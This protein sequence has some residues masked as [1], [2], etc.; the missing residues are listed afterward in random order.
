MPTVDSQRCEILTA[1]EN[2]VSAVI[3]E[4]Y[5]LRTEHAA[6]KLGKLPS[7][8]ELAISLD[9]ARHTE[10]ELRTHVEQHRCK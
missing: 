9:H 4:V 3:D 8:G 10:R 7:E 2:R 5:R 1:L 6:A